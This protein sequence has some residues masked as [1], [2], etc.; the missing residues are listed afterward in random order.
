MPRS[1]VDMFDCP[2]CGFGT[3]TLHEGYCEECRDE[4][5]HALD[6][7]NIEFDHWQANPRPYDMGEALYTAQRLIRANSCPG[8]K[9]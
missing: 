3:E 1:P 8:D 5:Q 4:N 6:A 9:S 2:Q 7:H